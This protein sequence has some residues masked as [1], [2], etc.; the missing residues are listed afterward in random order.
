MR[1]LFGYQ[2]VSQWLYGIHWMLYI[3]SQH[4]F[5]SGVC[6]Y[7]SSKPRTT[8]KTPGGESG[9]RSGSTALDDTGQ[10]ISWH[11]SRNQLIV[12]TA[13]SEKQVVD[14]ISACWK[15]NHR[16]VHEE[17]EAMRKTAISREHN[18]LSLQ[19]NSMCNRKARPLD[20]NQVLQI[21]H[22]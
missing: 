3:S 8:S 16:L 2:W 1:F 17:R 6:R 11:W 7:L 14:S 13:D 4:V 19:A 15:T 12:Y 21:R 5:G 22:T 18:W 9:G 20:W 10:G